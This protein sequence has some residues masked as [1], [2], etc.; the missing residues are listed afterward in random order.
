MTNQHTRRGTLIIVVAGM[1]AL[2]ATLAVTFAVKVRGE[3][4]GADQMA[5]IAQARILLNAFMSYSMFQ[6]DSRPPGPTQVKDGLEQGVFGPLHLPLLTSTFKLQ[7]ADPDRQAT[8]NTAWMVVGPAVVD[9]L[10][11]D[12]YKVTLLVGS[13]PTQGDTSPKTDRLYEPR[14][15]FDITYSPPPGPGPLVTTKVTISKI[16]STDISQ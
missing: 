1:S 10:N 13:G 16:E 5:R 14:Y 7:L 11:A 12:S 8:F 9:P 6:I 4:H 2:L 3:A 15:Q